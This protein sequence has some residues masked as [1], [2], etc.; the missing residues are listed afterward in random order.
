MSD[1]HDTKDELAER[2]V[3]QA[4]GEVLGKKQPPDLTE[5]ILKAAQPVMVPAR[6]ASVRTRYAVA[7]CLFVAA[8]GALLAYSVVTNELLTVAYRGGSPVTAELQTPT[9]RGSFVSEATERDEAVLIDRSESVQGMYGVQK[10]TYTGGMGGMGGMA[11]A[12]MGGAAGASGGLTGTGYTVSEL[13]SI[14]NGGTRG[15]MGMEAA[16][17]GGFPGFDPRFGTAGPNALAG[18]GEPDQGRGPGE[19]GD[20]YSRIVENPFLLATENPLSTF[21]IDVDTASYAKVRRYLLDNNM[22]PPPDAVRIEEFLNYF[23]YDYPGPE[24]EKPFAAHVEVAAC[25]WQP[26]HRLVRIGLKGREIPN[27]ERPAS[28]LVFLVDVSG[29]MQP[30]NKLPLVRRAMRMLVEQLGEND[31]VA[32]VVYASATGL[33]LPSTPGYRQSDIVAALENLQAGGSTNGGAGIRLAY[34]TATANFIKGGTNRVI[35]CTDG[36]FNVGTTS[37]AELERLVQEKA[38]TGV[39]LT[40]LGFGMGNHNDDMLEKLADKGNGNYAYIDS[41]QEAK[42]VLVDQMGGT[43]VAIAKDVKVQVEFNPRRVGGYRLIGYENRMLRAEDFNDDKKDAGEIGAGHTVTALYEVVP[44][45]AT[46]DIPGV[47]P[48]KYQKRTD[49]TEAAAGD[50]LLTVKLKYKK[51]DDE[52][53]QQALEYPIKDAGNEFGKASADFKF[54]AAVASFGML[55]RD[56]AHKGTTSYDA[57]IEIAQDGLGA[58]GH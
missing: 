42:K 55:L 41:E 49:L 21:S 37:T 4:L 10:P 29:S 32:I 1:T 46:A 26:E 31:R 38:Q 57:V 6:S 18:K 33:V 48:L 15:A 9:S 23:S 5:S 44:A 40:V 17:G 56:S 36:D 53:S 7:A 3:D 13:N 50:E 20:R 43:L 14:P 28:N 12:G 19:G 30:E 11:G 54:A 27:D 58:D 2:L 35:L 47:E 8:S 22:L 16:R 51:P 25:P 45:G 39:F 34:D 24:D 52:K